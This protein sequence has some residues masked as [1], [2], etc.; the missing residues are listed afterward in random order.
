ML[1]GLSLAVAL[2]IA[3]TTAAFAGNA[4][5]SEPAGGKYKQVSTL[6]ALPEFIPGLGA[7]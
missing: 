5:L 7:L 1:K 2:T 4:A 6:V 3:T